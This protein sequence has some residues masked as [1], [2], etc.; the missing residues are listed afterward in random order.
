MKNYNIQKDVFDWLKAAGFQRSET[1]MQKTVIDGF[2]SEI[3]ETFLAY[4]QNDKSAVLDGLVDSTWMY[5]NMAYFK[6]DNRICHFA[7]SEL[8]RVEQFGVADAIS[9]SRAE[10]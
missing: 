5:L 4:Q 7:N 3:G 10:L 8:Y 9:F 1:D 6:V 2:W